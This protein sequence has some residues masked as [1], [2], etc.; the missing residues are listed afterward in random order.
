MQEI[1]DRHGGRAPS[2]TSHSNSRPPERSELEFLVAAARRQAHIVIIGSIVG[3]ALGVGY[4][5]TA[6]PHYTAS[7]LVLLDNKRVR[8]VQESYGEVPGFGFE[9]ASPLDSQVEVL[10]SDS[11]I[12]S[13]VDRL[14]LVRDR[15]FR[16][17]RP[18]LLSVAMAEFW[19]MLG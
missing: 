4:L 13:V 18:G 1:V 12:N 19:R 8:A 7:A 15:E 6:V 5:V 10:R 17:S 2:L 9:G 14:Q 16:A 3:I 11:V